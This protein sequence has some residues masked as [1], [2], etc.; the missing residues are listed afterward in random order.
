MSRIHVV[1]A[2]ALLTAA[3]ASTSTNQPAPMRVADFKPE[4]VRRPVF[5]VRFAFSSEFDGRERQDQRSDYE[6]ALLEGLNTRAV[7]ARDVRF[8]G[9]REPRLLAPAALAT[10]RE[11]GA[12]HAVLVEVRAGRS[13]QPL[14]CQETRRPFRAP[15]AV[16]GQTVQVFRTSDGAMRLAVPPGGGLEVYD[17]EADCDNPR[18]SKRRTATEAL[19][20]AVTKL[21][22]RVVG[23]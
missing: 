13:A 14:F 22:G 10:A 4:Q 3:C 12:D 9:D 20:D 21:L 23:P 5:F 7:L 6:G 15:A 18:Q 1:V 19:N 16:W 2:L 17:L 11:L 8:S